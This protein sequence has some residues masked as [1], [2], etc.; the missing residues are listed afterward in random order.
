MKI[1][2]PLKVDVLADFVDN[3]LTQLLLRT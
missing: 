3:G 1:P 2:V